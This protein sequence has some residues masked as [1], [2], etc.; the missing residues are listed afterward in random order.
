MAYCLRNSV[1][2]ERGFWTLIGAAFGGISARI[3]LRRAGL[4]VLPLHI[5]AFAIAFAF[6]LFGGAG[7]AHAEVLV[8]NI[9]QSSGTS[10]EPTSGV[11]IFQGFRTGSTRSGYELTSIEI[12]FT[13][14]TTAPTVKLF[15]DS[16]LDAEDTGTEVATLTAP[17]NF[18]SG[19]KTFTIPD[20]DNPPVLAHST[21]YHVSVTG[22]SASLTL[23]TTPNEDA[24]G[25]S[26]WNVHDEIYK[27]TAGENF[28]LFRIRMRIRVNGTEIGP[29][30]S[31]VAVTSIPRATDNT[32]GVGQR[33]EFTV[34]FNQ[35][36]TVT[37]EPHFEFEL[38][39]TDTSA[40]FIGGSGT[41]ELV[42]GYTVQAS[43]TD[44]NGIHVGEDGIKLGSD[45]H[46]RDADNTLDA[47]LTHSELGTL[48]GHQ[49]NG[50]L[51]PRSTD[52]TLSALSLGTGVTLSPAFASDITTYRAWVAN[53]VS[54]V[55]VTATKNDDGATV[56]ITPG[57][58][59]IPLTPGR[60]QIAVEVTAEFPSV[61]E[62]YTVTVVRE[63]SAPSADP[64]VDLT[65][66]VT[67]GEGSGT[68]GYSGGSPG[69]GAM[70]ETRFQV[71]GA[72]YD[73]RAVVLAGDAPASPFNA[74][75]V[76]LCFGAREP[77]NIVRNSLTLSIDG[78]DFAFE[79]RSRLGTSRCYD[80]TRPV[81]LDW[82]WGDIALV[83]LSGNLP[84]EFGSRVARRNVFA[85]TPANENVGA[86]VEAVDLDG[87]V[88]IYTLE[89]V[90]RNNFTIDD[91]G[92]IK[93]RAPLDPQ[94]QNTR[95]VTVKADDG[96]GGTATIAVIITVKAIVTEVVVT[97]VKGPRYS[98]TSLVARWTEP[99]RVDALVPTGYAVQYRE[100][101]SGPW[102]RHP[103]SGTATL[104]LIGSLSAGTQ[105]QVRVYALYGE[106]VPPS[107]WSEP[108]TGRVRT[109]VG[110]ASFGTLGATIYQTQHLGTVPGAHFGESFEVK[111]RFTNPLTYRHDITDITGPNG[112]IF[113]NPGPELA[114]MIGP[115]RGIWV[116]SGTVESINI[117]DRRLL[118]LNVQPSGN[119]DI[120]LTLEPLP[121]NEQGA[122]CSGQEG[123][124][125]RVRY[126]VRGVKDVPPAPRDLQVKTVQ[127]GEDELMKVSFDGTNEATKSRVQW[128]FPDQEWSEAEEHW[129]W[130]SVGPEGRHLSVSA[131][132]NPALSYDVRARW[133]SPIGEGPWAYTTR[134]GVPRA[135]WGETIRWYQSFDTDGNV[136]GAEVHIEYGRALNI[137]APIDL[138][139]NT[140]TTP[141]F[142]VAY[143]ESR[144]LSH[145]VRGMR[146]IDTTDDNTYNPRTVKLTLSSV[147]RGPNATSYASP[148]TE[149]QVYVTY[150]ENTGLP[151]LDKA[152]SPAPAF[153]SLSATFVSGA[154]PAE[155]RRRSA[156]PVSGQLISSGNQIY[157]TFDWK[158]SPLGIPSPDAFTIKVDGTPIGTIFAPDRFTIFDENVRNIR[159][160]VSP[161]IRQGQTVTVTYNKP[162]N[163]NKTLRDRAG[164]QVDSFED[165]EVT[166]NSDLGPSSQGFGPAAVSAAVSASGAQILLTMDEAVDLNNI[167]SKSTF[168]ITVDGTGHSPSSVD[169][170]F[171]TD[172]YILYL[173]TIINKDQVVTIGYTDPNPGRDNSAGVIQDTDGNDGPS[174]TNFRVTN[175]STVVQGSALSVADAEAT[176][177]IHEMLNFVVTLNPAATTSVTV[178]YTTSDGTATQGNDYTI[179]SGTLTFL[180]G[181]TTKTV[182]VPI[183]DDLEEDD[184]ETLMLTLSNAV[185]ARL[186]DA[187]AIGTIRNT[188][189]ALTAEFRDISVDAHDG[190]T[191]FTFELR[192]S[193][194]VTG[195]GHTTLRNHAFTVTNGQVT[196]ARRLEVGKNQRWEI[197]VEP[198]GN[199][200]VTI[201][202]PETT[203]CGDTGAIC[204]GT[205][206]LSAGDSVTVRGSPPVTVPPAPLTAEIRDI[207]VTTHDG[208]TAFTFELRFSEDW[209]AG[210]SYATL[211]D[212]AFTVTN[213]EVT[214]VRRLEAGKNQ[215]WEITVAPDG[216]ADVTIELPAT[217]DCGDTGAICIGTRPLSAGDSVTV[218]GPAPVTENPS[219]VTENPPPVTENP[220][221]LTENSPPLTAEIRDISATTHDGSTAFTFELRFSEEVSGLSYTTLRNDAFTVTNGEVTGVRRLEAGKSQRWE[222]TVAPDGDEDVV[223]TLPVTTDCGDQGA[224]CIGEDRMLS[225]RLERTVT[226]DPVSIQDANLLTAIRG[227][228]EL[229]DNE[230]LTQAKMAD[231]TELRAAERGISNISGLEHATSLTTVRLA[232]NQISNLSALSGLT[233]LTTLRVQ[234]NNIS[235]IAALSGLTNLTELFLNNNQITDITPLGG[236]TNL[237][238]L[239]L[240]GNSFANTG[241]N[242]QTLNAL[243]AAGV[244]IDI[245]GNTLLLPNY[246]NPFNP[247]TWIPY[248]LGADSE[249]EIVI[250]DVRGA[251]VR[252]LRLG[253]RAA[254]IYQHPGRA[255]YWDGR[256]VL[257]KRVANGVYF[258]QLRTNNMSVVGRMVVLK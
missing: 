67:V 126:T 212:S 17:S 175:S 215:R 82:A 108:G 110:D 59:T 220:P 112:E 18:G 233:S 205:R 140:G 221:P 77:E 194:D 34:T 214:G 70:T 28:T 150:T 14:G 58:A 162:N 189:E 185:G 48:S 209:T 9:G 109:V 218:R 64:N 50:S 92:Q 165:F 10:T 138:F 7:L 23:T 238:R 239:K 240:A 134:A 40:P 47:V 168:T 102:R 26:D 11:D 118:V 37:G 171:G 60:N 111:V 63:A 178:E 253:H 66:N 223:I 84:P 195:L 256:D 172:S 30:V 164:N 241:D 144:A 104:T 127:E 121:C 255:A 258:Y 204:I 248:Q 45:E 130:W 252:Y 24:S 33:I 54:S 187:E 97:S 1:Q 105:Y 99:V 137:D 101:T 203:D 128:K 202:L 155:F 167:P 43:D 91:S 98:T 79:G 231:L 32:Y 95:Q 86:P 133:E 39:G 81:D 31:S 103:H 83:K 139:N 234:N 193:E 156:R 192:F 44:I 236:L 113:I 177:N 163:A 115:D 154:P 89:G 153:N 52:A 16:D 72:T 232:R 41:N 5:A 213:G 216:N 244:D 225:T 4:R 226:R 151:V 6:P 57:T 27:R 20:S 196:G 90:D 207:S 71:G 199:A 161:R 119:D 186:A 125:D 13:S 69:W 242:A 149:E 179:T 166:N 211:R 160:G 182:S 87:D 74:N 157:V 184:G 36:V 210:L 53:G 145:S 93:T 117:F 237:L 94:G 143:S 235:S 3:R 62:E 191:A 228:L 51:I 135:Q 21:N 170:G 76:A 173:T 65:A 146:I 227:S 38:G 88:L 224:I 147:I 46:I 123:L 208:S 183:T 141:P 116:T 200:D 107:E 249:V 254:G 181:E 136:N 73:V 229:S 19:N 247:E 96:K 35:E 15:V 176:E 12:R 56:V 42:F 174:F 22:G 129:R 159:L 198:D 158:L 29:T 142:R 8:S 100:G 197:T 124:A 25:K 152:G 68:V 206:P 222:I 250:Y 169:G 246:P 61:T 2:H 230:A 219:P 80:W 132:V 245:S 122:L 75:R 55:S 106:G 120:T 243:I 49:V 78:H 201:E 148:H 251:V 180:P 217:A 85:N 114:D 257:G 190:S 188:E 131:R